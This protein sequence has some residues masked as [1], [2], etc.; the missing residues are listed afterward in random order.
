MNS[1]KIL[2]IY[3]IIS[4]LL[5]SVIG[6]LTAFNPVKIKANEGIEIAGNAS[7]L[8]DVRAFGILL[9]AI[10]ILSFSGAIKTA[11]R[12]TAAITL[13]LLFISL[14]IGRVISVVLDGMPSEG[15]VKATI[16]EFVL[17]FIGATLY[18]INKKYFND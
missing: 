13:P 12:K 5:L 1:L 16:L 3:L 10:A 8:N 7:A 15:M 18:F 4:G 17:G 9:L 14:G 2:K 6:T 11:I